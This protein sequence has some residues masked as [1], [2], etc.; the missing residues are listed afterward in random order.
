MFDSKIFTAIF[1][2]LL[3]IHWQFIDSINDNYGD[4]NLE[5]KEINGIIKWRDN[6]VNL[7]SEKVYATLNKNR[8]TIYNNQYLKKATN[9]QVINLFD[10]TSNKVMINRNVVLNEID[11]LRYAPLY[12]FNLKR[13]NYVLCSKSNVDRRS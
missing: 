4:S 8:L 9:K 12:R 10:D 1:F 11:T 7:V 6:Q 3:L 5:N 2:I 13:I